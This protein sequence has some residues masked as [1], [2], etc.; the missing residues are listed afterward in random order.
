MGSVVRGL[1]RLDPSIDNGELCA[2]IAEACAGMFSL[3]VGVHDLL[4][5]VE[6]EGLLDEIKEEL[7]ALLPQPAAASSAG[8][9]DQR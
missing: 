5:A 9:S 2:A 1:V 4:Q 7:K 6:F 8:C 3:L